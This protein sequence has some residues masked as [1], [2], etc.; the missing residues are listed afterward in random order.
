MFHVVAG[1]DDNEERALEQAE[2]IASL[3]AAPDEI[4]VTV[5]HTFTF[6]A[7]DTSIDDIEAVAAVAETLEER[8]IQCEVHEGNGEPS[9]Y[10]V[11]YAA[12]QG[13]D[14]ICVGG[15]KR[16]P[17]GK[18]LFG[19]VSQQVLLGSDRPVLVTPNP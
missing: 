19:S 4:T 10:L 2:T 11:Q 8:G 7:P 12:E 6:K 9:E 13:A 15:R 18:A 1:V 3:P 17:A 14:L 16:T 5:V